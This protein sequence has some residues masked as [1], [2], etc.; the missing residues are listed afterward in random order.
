MHRSFLIFSLLLLLLLCLLTA[1]GGAGSAAT[2]TTAPTGGTDTAAPPSAAETETAQTPPYTVTVV[3]PT[4]EGVT[5][6]GGAPIQSVMSAADFTPVEIA[7]AEDYTYSGY[8]I[9]GVIYTGTTLTLQGEI[10]ADTEIRLLVG[11]LTDELPVVSISTNGVAVTSRNEYV[12][13][14]FT[15]SGCEGEPS[16][17]PG[18]IRVRGNSTATFPKLPYRIRFEQKHSLFGL[19]KAKSWVLL[20]DYLDPSTLHNYAALTLAGTS[21]SFDF[22]PTP[23]KVNLYLNGAYA[24]IYTL[25]EQVQEQAGRL[26]LKG[27]IT[28]DMRA[29]SDYTFLICLNYNAPEK[30]GAVEGE[31]YFYLPSCDRYFE[32]EYPRKEDFPTEAQF[33]DFFD[34]LVAFV[35]DT[36][37]A[38]RQANRAYLNKNVD[39]DSLIDMFIVDQIMGERDHHWKSLFM[40]YTGAKG[41][42]TLHFGPPWDYDFCMFTEWTGEPNEDFTVHNKIN[43]HE[44][45]LFYRPLLDNPR[46]YERVRE[47]YC[48]HFSDALAE[49]AASVEALAERM[50]ESLALNQTE[51][52]EDTPT[53]TEDNVEFFVKYLKSRKAYLD[54]EWRE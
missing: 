35:D 43:S 14:T 38:C 30:A 3:C 54:R 28:A 18:G 40:Y 49:V 46:Y 33:Y 21:D 2:E 52:Y 4:P 20:A 8:E 23:H 1:C 12:D 51:W 47:R 26:D 7:V 45:S 5:L 44:A 50:G 13:M 36:V 17:I 24:G 53:I 10:S 42:A 34:A 39:M 29:L 27:E 22:V 11:Y 32:L 19:D 37:I 16:G 25:C 41:D 6:S 15:L 48:T 31:T 9:G